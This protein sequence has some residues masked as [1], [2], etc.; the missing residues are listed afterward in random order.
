VCISASKLVSEGLERRSAGFTY[1]QGSGDDHESW[2]RG[3]TPEMYWK[4]K[5][6]LLSLSRSTL[7]EGI[8]ALLAADSG[9]DSA[10][11]TI[12]PVFRTGSRLAI[13][14]LSALTSELLSDGRAYVI[15]VTDI[16]TIPSIASDSILCL[17][18][19]AGKKGQ[20]QLLTDVVPRSL[21]FLKHHLTSNKNAVVLCVDGK[22]ISVGVVLVAMCSFFDDDGV[23]MSSNDAN[24][25]RQFIFNINT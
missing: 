13:G 12:V 20:L 18:V 10:A 3:L 6:Y 8:S 25:A 4:N 22:D 17:Q 9:V 23:F 14:T 16:S 11:G 21:Q 1:V 19:P 24:N 15:L 7:L 5:E 2:S